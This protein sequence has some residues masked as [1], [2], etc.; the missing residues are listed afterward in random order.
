VPAGDHSTDLR[1]VLATI[2]DSRWNG[3]GGDIS[4]RGEALNIRHPSVV[5][6]SATPRDTPVERQPSLL[7]GDDR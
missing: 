6:C 1:W 3:S 2:P 5:K 4:E 7:A